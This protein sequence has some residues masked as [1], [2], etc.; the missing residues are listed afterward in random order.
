MKY[1]ADAPRTLTA[2]ESRLLAYGLT[3]RE[4]VTLAGS[5]GLDLSAASDAEIEQAVILALVTAKEST[6]GPADVEYVF[7]ERRDLRRERYRD[8]RIRA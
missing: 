1:L 5:I 8:L 4:A 3:E 7:G 6:S 2:T